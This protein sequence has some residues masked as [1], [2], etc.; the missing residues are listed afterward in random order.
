MKKFKSVH[1]F[2]KKMLNEGLIPSNWS[3]SFQFFKVPTVFI[4]LDYFVENHSW[5]SKIRKKIFFSYI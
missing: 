2:E 5:P 1:F 3:I 4:F